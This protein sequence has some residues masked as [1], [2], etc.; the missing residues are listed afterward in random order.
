M[1]IGSFESGRSVPQWLKDYRVCLTDANDYC[2]Q[3]SKSVDFRFHYMKV[4][5]F[6]L[7]MIEF[8]FTEASEGEKISR[9]ETI[10]LNDIIIDDRAYDT[11]KVGEIAVNYISNCSVFITA[12]SLLICLKIF[13]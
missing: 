8:H 13:Q 7:N 10:R 3:S 4:E 11:S 5:L 2:K 6:T 9:Y 1:D 12:H